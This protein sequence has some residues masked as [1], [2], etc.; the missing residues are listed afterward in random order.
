M[1]ADLDA[2][3]GGH[4][5]FFFGATP[6]S[7]DAVVFG[8]LAQAMTLVDLSDRLPAYKNL[9]RCASRLA[10]RLSVPG[11]GWAGEGG[12]AGEGSRR[13]ELRGGGGDV[14]HDLLCRADYVNSL[15]VFNQLA[16]RCERI[17]EA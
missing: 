10:W 17:C 12:G 6:T 8:H 9:F 5:A 13:R 11:T 1:Y 14:L 16:V 3:M 2:R 15:N 4:N 7:L